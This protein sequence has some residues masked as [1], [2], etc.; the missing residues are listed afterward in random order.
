M[1]YIPKYCGTPFSLL[2]TVLN[3]NFSIS[4]YRG[5][6]D[7]MCALLARYTACSGNS[8]P[9]FGTTF[10]SHLQGSAVQEGFFGLL[11]RNFGKELLLYASNIP[12]GRRSDLELYIKIQFLPRSEH[13]S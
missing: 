10:R 9:T 11:T 2:N 1:V 3:R 12:A 4:V 6:V 5:E 13:N 8:L 7:E